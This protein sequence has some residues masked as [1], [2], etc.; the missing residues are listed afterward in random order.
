MHANTD[1]AVGH[2]FLER[3]PRH[4]AR[5]EIDEHLKHMPAVTGVAARRQ[6][7]AGVAAEFLEIARGQRPAPCIEPVQA[8]Q[9]VD[10]DL[11]RDVG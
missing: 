6:Y 3:R 4:A 5:P 7:H 8:A 9:L 11:R 10:A 2:D 1:A